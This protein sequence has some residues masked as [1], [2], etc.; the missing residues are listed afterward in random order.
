MK[1]VNKLGHLDQATRYD[2]FLIGKTASGIEKK[3]ILSD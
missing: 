3:L 1:R 2:E